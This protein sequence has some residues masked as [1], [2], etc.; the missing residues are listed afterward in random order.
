METE[1]RTY[2]TVILPNRYSSEEVLHLLFVRS[3]TIY[4]LHGASIH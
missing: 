2:L 4:I 1:K 3:Q